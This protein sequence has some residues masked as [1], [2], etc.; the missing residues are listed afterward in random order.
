MKPNIVVVI[1]NWNG[2][3]HIGA[4]LE[5][6]ASQST[7]HTAVVVDNGSVDNS[8]EV[9]EKSF[10]TVHIEKLP[11]NLGFDGGVNVGIEWAKTQ[12]AELI[13]IFNNDALA[14]KDW[15]KHL[16]ARMEKDTT[17]GIVSCKQ[18]RDDKT[19]I[20][21]TGDFYSIWGLPFPRGRNHEDTG[22]YDAA[23]ELFCAP[24]GATLYRTALFDDIGAFDETF[25]AY[26]ED[27]DIS[28]RARL[29]GWKIWYEPKAVVFHEVSATSSK[30]GGF[31]RFHSTK[32]FHILFLKNMPGI[33]FW[34][35]FPLAVLQS[36]RLAL[37]SISHGQLLTHF[38]GYF[39]AV[40]LIPH[41]LIERKRIQRSRKVSIS[42][43]DDWLY[44]GRPPKIPTID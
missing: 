29:A 13:G 15:L 38:R 33:L 32:N 9:I 22:Q 27:V 41:A 5:S 42:Q 6:L 24:A 10:P 20:D 36:L 28:F 2:A 18:L 16:V 30:L 8:I 40:K 4:C 25:F 19:H 26:Y 7:A 11:K 34:K 17:T 35:Y 3:E 44:H 39:A 1:P 37:G 31:T 21:S 23:E 12:N 14:D 43:V